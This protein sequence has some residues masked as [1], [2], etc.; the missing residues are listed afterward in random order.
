MLVF[1]L[2]ISAACKLYQDNCKEKVEKRNVCVY[3]F[4]K[5]DFELYDNVCDVMKKQCNKESSK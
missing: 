3:N 5:R 4:Y 2:E 1:E